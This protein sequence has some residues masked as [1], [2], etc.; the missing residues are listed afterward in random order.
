MDRE[1]LDAIKDPVMHLVRNGVDHGLETPEEREAAGKPAEASILISLQ[2]HG[3]R[4]RLEVADDGR[5]V[6]AADIRAHAE[7]RGVLREAELAQMDDDAVRMLVFRPGFTSSEQVSE[8][9]GRGVGLDVVQESVERLAGNVHME[10]IEGVGTKFVL[11]VPVSQ[12]TARMLLLEVGTELFALPVASVERVLQVGS[13]E[14]SKVETGQAIEF[15]GR[16]IHIHR[17]GDLLNCNQR[18]DAG[19]VV[20]AIVLNSFNERVALVV[21]RIV[22]ERELITKGLGDHL[23][24]VPNVAA[25]TVLA[26]GRVVPVLNTTDLVR[27]SRALEGQGELF[28]RASND[29]MDLQT[30]L[31][32]D[33][34][35]TTRTLER[36]ILEAAGYQVR[37]ATDGVEALDA[38]SQGSVDLILADIQMPR[39]DGFQLTET[40]KGNERTASIPVVLVTSLASDEDRARGMHAGADAYVVK[41]EF[42]QGALLEILGKLI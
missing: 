22:D 21:D 13:S 41:S 35:I 40:V 15:E 19:A 27:G 5:G 38:L 16:P 20:T 31:V 11:T 30:I 23:E 36:S 18:S 3:N 4:L 32:V 9:S 7:R 39:M 42:Q 8:V 37:V 17:L 33:D 24:Q 26:N 34:S 29:G 10:T 14:V 28:T 25:T 6:S 1:V 2:T 12:A